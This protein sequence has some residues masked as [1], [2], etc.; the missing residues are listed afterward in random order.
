MNI[1]VR[2]HHCDELSRV[3]ESALG[4]Y[5]SCPRCAR[6]FSANPESVP[7]VS[8]REVPT[9]YPPSHAHADYPDPH[10]T[11]ESHRSFLFGLAML[12]LL[13]PIFWLLGPLLTGKPAIFT[14]ALPCAIGLSAVG[15]CL[16]A[17]F[18]ADWTFGTR[19]KS[20]FAIFFVASFSASFLY[21]LKTEWVEEF[22]RRTSNGNDEF[23]VDFEPPDHK[24]KVRVPG[25][26]MKA[27]ATP[28]LEG[29]E[30]TGYR[31]TGAR[32]LQTFYVAHGR[33]PDD[34]KNSP[35]EKFFDEVRARLLLASR[36]V[37]VDEPKAVRYPPYPGYE[38]VIAMPDRASKRIVRVVRIERF[39][40]VAAVEGAFLP[41]DAR[42][43]RK[44]FD[45]IKLNTGK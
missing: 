21:F 39:V 40:F 8:P 44:Y 1:A 16:G 45:T 19:V 27:D 9:V 36:G 42:V 15:L 7:T 18:A 38:Y 37:L 26:G 4:R 14:Y 24:Y 29:W 28:L 41:P 33:V 11:P 3:P 6:P 5:V 35:P 22:R 12:P 43:V 2:C 30:L 17:V 32:L 10:D 34:L 31:S 20:I 25:S 13:I 23:W